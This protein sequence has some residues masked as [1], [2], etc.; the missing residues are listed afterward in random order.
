MSLT[1]AAL[2]AQDNLDSDDWYDER[3]RVRGKAR[4][5]KPDDPKA[6]A[7]ALFAKICEWIE[8]S[9]QKHITV[10]SNQIA[11]TLPGGPYPRRVMKIVIKRFKD[12]GFAAENRFNDG[13]ND[14]DYFI[15]TL[16][17]D[18]LGRLLR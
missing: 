6:E 17:E 4:D 5:R 16:P 7:E 3:E 2:S 12:K 18:W 1:S 11:I 14:F 10:Q 9:L 15:L 13:F 8:A